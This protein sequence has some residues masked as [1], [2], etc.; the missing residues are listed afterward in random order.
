MKSWRVLESC[1]EVTGFHLHGLHV[2]WGNVSYESL[3]S[4]EG[5]AP[6][7]GMT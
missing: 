1:S 7:P 5:L 3:P 4:A 2:V 6:W